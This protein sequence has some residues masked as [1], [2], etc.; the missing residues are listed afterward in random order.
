MGARRVLRVNLCVYVCDRKHHYEFV[1]KWQSH[2]SANGGPV[3]KYSIK[4]ALRRVCRL[5]GVCVGGAQA[6]LK[7]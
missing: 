7:T 6:G 4:S 1:G 3:F 2:H 5:M